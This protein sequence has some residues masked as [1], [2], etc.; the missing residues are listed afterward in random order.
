MN[1]KI[2]DLLDDYLDGDVYM[3]PVPVPDTKRIKEAAMKKVKKQRTVRPLRV[4]L[5][6]A[7]VVVLLTGTALAVVHYTRSADVLEQRW[8]LFGEEQMTQ[9]QKDY[10]EQR[11]ANIG[12]HVTDQGITVTVDSVTCVTDRVYLALRYEFAPEQY[13]QVAEC[14]AIGWNCY[15]NNESIGT[16]ENSRLGERLV[17]TSGPGVFESEISATFADLPEGANLGD[18]KTTLRLEISQICWKDQVDGP[19]EFTVDGSWTFEFPLPQSEAPENKTSDAVLSFDGTEL[20]FGENLL[21]QIEDI[22][23]SETACKFTVTTDNE[24]YIF[25][26]GDGVQAELARA[27]EPDVLFLT[28]FAVMDDGA[29]AYGGAGM[30]WDES[31]DKDH[32]SVEWATPLDPA[33]VVSLIFSDGTTE[34]EAPLS[35]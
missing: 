20:D 7:A 16:M 25:I 33:S 15:A 27:A 10:L 9:E 24:D 2:T 29:M 22:Q 32:W 30:T 6:A 26:G 19:N 18:G 3:D 8:G 17:E 5:I 21:L 12:E 11:S 1:L 23:V 34:I 4:A 14:A 31:T 28:V 35:E 13:E